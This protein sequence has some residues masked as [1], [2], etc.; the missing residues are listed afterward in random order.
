MTI[1]SSVGSFLS[2]VSQPVSS[3]PSWFAT[4]SACV[5]KLH[6]MLPVVLKLHPYPGDGCHSDPF[7][8]GNVFGLLS[9]NGCMQLIWW[10][11]WCLMW[12]FS[13]R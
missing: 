8:F 3:V 10:F 4:V 2:L 1:C 13:D 9:L 12:L 5:V 6:M 11:L 7:F